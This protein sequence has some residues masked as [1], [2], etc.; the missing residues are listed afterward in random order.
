MRAN[1]F[2]RALVGFAC[3]M[4]VGA[5][6]TGCVIIPPPLGAFPRSGPRVPS[7]PLA[8]FAPFAPTK[9]AA[10]PVSLTLRN[11]VPVVRLCEAV[12]VGWIDLSESLIAD[13]PSKGYV[14]VWVA[15][16]DARL[17]KGIEFV[18]GTAPHGLKQTASGKETFDFTDDYWELV[19]YNFD[20]TSKPITQ[21]FRAQDLVE[22][23]W[24]DYKG[25]AAAGP[26][27]LS[28]DTD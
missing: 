3:A 22:G 14:D 11:G 21:K 20:G 12:T 8:P 10:N 13:D 17:V 19:L 24:L 16:G 18:V 5:A 25:R 28:S 9:L 6:L 23:F 15:V 27:E 4:A 26:C 1:T 2:G 7:V